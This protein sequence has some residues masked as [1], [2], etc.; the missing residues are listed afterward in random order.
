M[1]SNDFF[2]GNNFSGRS[3]ALLFIQNK[4]GRDKTLIQNKYNM[5]RSSDK[6]CLQVKIII[7]D[8]L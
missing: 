7:V 5:D 2:E 3:H 8:L 6:I 1:K 4:Y